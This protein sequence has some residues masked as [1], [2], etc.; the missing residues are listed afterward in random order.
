MYSKTQSLIKDRQLLQNY[1]NQ[2][3]TLSDLLLNLLNTPVKTVHH[4]GGTAHFHYPTEPILDI[5]VGVNNL[6]D[7]TALDEKRLNYAGFYRL[8]HRY[9]KKV[10][11]AQ[12]NNLKELKQ[13]ARLH[14]LQIES[15]QY[16][17]YLT[18]QD[19]LTHHPELQTAF[20]QAK[21]RLHAQAESIREYEAGK[22]ALFENLSRK[23]GLN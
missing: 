16:E 4:I 6:H 15:D 7:I 11:M 5:L 9:K 19:A 20:S 22:T 10:V 13:I 17:H 18:M 2:F 14:I 8:H 23:L 21:Q 12:F 1:Q 3:Q